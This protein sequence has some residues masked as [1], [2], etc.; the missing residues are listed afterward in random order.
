M[1]LTFKDWNI[2]HAAL[3]TKAEAAR[4]D[5]K[6]HMEYYSDKENVTEVD[7]AEEKRLSAALKE[8]TDLLDK[9]ENA[10]IA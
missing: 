4:S 3:T 8:V 10:S 9:I 1:K 6:W 7:R 2:I 5:L